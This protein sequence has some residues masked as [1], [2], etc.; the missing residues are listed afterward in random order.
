MNNILDTQHFF[1]LEVQWKKDLF[2]KEHGKGFQMK[3]VQSGKSHGV[4][5]NK[6]V[7]ESWLEN[8]TFSSWPH[9]LVH[10]APPSFESPEQVLFSL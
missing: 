6:S 9:D 10:F 3:G 1:W 4:M 8:M 2:W 7:F 5:L